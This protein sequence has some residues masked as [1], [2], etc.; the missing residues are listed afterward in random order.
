ML[1]ISSLVFVL[2]TVAVP[3]RRRHL[4]VDCLGTPQAG[5]GWVAQSRAPKS[6]KMRP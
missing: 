6:A 3:P 5:G 4:A 2:G 1:L